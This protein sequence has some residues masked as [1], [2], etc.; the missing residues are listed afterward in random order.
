MVQYLGD[1]KKKKKKEAPVPGAEFVSMKEKLKAQM[2]ERRLEVRKKRVVEMKINENELCDDLPDEEEFDDEE[3]YNFNDEEEYLGEDEEKEDE[4]ESEPEENDVDMR[5][6]KRIKNA[7]E[8]DEA[9][10]EDMVDGDY[11]DDDDSIAMSEFPKKKSMPFKKIQENPELL[12]ETSCAS[13]SFKAAELVRNDMATPTIV[14]RT[15]LTSAPNSNSSTLQLPRFT[16]LRL[17]ICCLLMQTLRWT[18]YQ[19]RADVWGAQREEELANR[20]EGE[21]PT[22]SQLARKKLGFENLFDQTD[23]DVQE[24]DD[25]VD[26]GLLSGRFATQKPAAEMG[27]E[28]MQQTQADFSSSSIPQ[29]RPQSRN[30][31]TQDTVILTGASQDVSS[32]INK[33]L[34]DVGESSD[35]EDE[36]AGD[37]LGE[38]EVKEMGKVEGEDCSAQ[39]TIRPDLSSDVDEGGEEIKESDEGVKVSKK[40]KRRLISDSEGSEDEKEN[41][42]NSDDSEAIDEVG[43]L[44]VMRRI[45]YD[46]D[47]NPVAVAKPVKNRMLTKG[48]VCLLICL[49][50][51]RLLCENI[52]I[53]KWFQAVN[54]EKTSWR[55]RP[56]SREANW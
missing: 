23:P 11:D 44:G 55:A 40:R 25:V 26:M 53:E 42:R 51:Q 5:D 15:P 9:E 8:D 13:D 43:D 32:A 50:F 56:S 1:V 21:S 19:D 27:E 24:I 47:E 52:L 34:E 29:S 4:E 35:E 36:D 37:V 2:L 31:D 16:F 22:S 39:E 30:M 48:F 54:S 20:E 7:F 28:V 17:F 46:S 45:E 41:S 3:D 38:V 6:R 49:L 33:I 10:D 12:S 18:P 14:N